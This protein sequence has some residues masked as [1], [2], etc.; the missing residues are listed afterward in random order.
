MS[1]IIGTLRAI[2]RDELARQRHAEL[3][4][5][6]RVHAKDGDDSKNNHQVD[7]KLRGSDVELRRVPVAVGR[8]GVSALPNEGDLMI[9][10]FVG[11]DLN[12]AVAVGCVY[13]QER[14]PPV[15]ALHELVYQPPDP[16]ASGVKRLHLELQNGSTVTLD[17][18]S[19][20]VSL[21]D[22]SLVINKDG[23]LSIEAA[24][25]LKFKAGGKVTI[26][27]SGDVTITAQ[28]NLN[29]KGTSAALEGQ[30][31]AKVKGATLTI[32]GNT[33]FSPS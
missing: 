16:E 32:A 9:V 33:Q 13:D 11:G 7:L 20:Q 29:A 26:E 14:H 18:E 3:G 17:D 10:V 21:G 8:L 30:S 2:I 23:D 28:G 12:G 15:A 1:D 5:V 25:D 31:E 6:T 4:V 24:G 19:L 27:A 22:T